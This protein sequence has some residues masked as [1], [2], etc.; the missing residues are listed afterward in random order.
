MGKYQVAVNFTNLLYAA[1]FFTVCRPHTF[2]Q[3]EHL[4]EGR[5]ARIVACRCRGG[6]M[7]LRLRRLR[8]YP[9]SP[10]T[11]DPLRYLSLPRT[12]L[13]VDPLDRRNVFVGRSTLGKGAGEGLFARRAIP[14]DGLV[15]KWIY[16]ISFKKLMFNLQIASYGGLLTSTSLDAKEKCNEVS[17]FL[18]P[19]PP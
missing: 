11:L 3:T 14:K 7:E 5:A 8:Y 18:L 15:R 13:Q 10:Y 19:A 1:I 6:V 16:M 12:S 17:S 9:D 4:V 2:F